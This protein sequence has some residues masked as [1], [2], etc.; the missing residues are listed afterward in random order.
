MRFRLRRDRSAETEPCQAQPGRGRF[1]RPEQVPAVDP[2]EEA[3][4]PPADAF[5]VSRI[6]A[7][8]DG[9]FAIAI[10]LLVFGL[11]VPDI[12]EPTSADE[13]AHALGDMWPRFGAYVQTFLI[14]GAYWV[15]HHRVF[16]RMVREDDR[17]AWL[18]LLFLMTVS[19]MPFPATMQGRYP[20][21]RTALVVFSGSLAAVSLT[22]VAVWAYAHRSHL[23]APGTRHAAR[24]EIWTGVS[25]AGL[26]LVSIP[27]AFADLDLAALCGNAVL[28]VLVMSN[29]AYRRMAR[30]S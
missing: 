7:L 17:L 6:A 28:L 4:T 26:F 14:L 27:L 20:G 25:A 13:L 24:I 29:R 21:N 12:S 18:N 1:G 11:E 22:Y 16:R 30:L 10:T 9:I 8:S 23:L 2:A 19:F 3:R 15:G 5:G